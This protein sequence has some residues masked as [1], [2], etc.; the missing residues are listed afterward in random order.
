VG[1]I[2]I[3]TVIT[4]NVQLNSASVATK[5]SDKRSVFELLA[6]LSKSSAVA[7]ATVMAP[8][9]A[10]INPS[11]RNVPSD[12]DVK[13]SADAGASKKKIDFLEECGNTTS[14]TAANA[15]PKTD[16]NNTH[17]NEWLIQSDRSRELESIPNA[18]VDPE[19]NNAEIVCGINGEPMSIRSRWPL[20]AML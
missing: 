2:I 20:L 16:I 14:H 18:T 1:I 7:N 8:A 12:R 19:F 11:S 4:I 3:K 6:E 10:V 9:V 5:N 17:V 15:Y 13:A